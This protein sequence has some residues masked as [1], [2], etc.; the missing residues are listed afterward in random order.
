[1]IPAGN[2]LAFSVASLLLVLL[3][4]PSVLFAIGWALA[5]GRRAAVISVVGNASGMYVQ[6]VAVSLGLGVLLQESIILLTIVKFAGAAFLLYLGIQAIRHRN[7]LVA[8]AAT[9]RRSGVLRTFFE[10]SVVGVTNPKTIV[11]FLAILPQ[12]VDVSGETAVG[13]QMLALG[14]IFVTLGVIFDSLYAILA[15]VARGWLGRSPGRLSGLGVV[16]GV[17]MIGLGVGL[18]VTGT[19]ESA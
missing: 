4:G 6:V 16:G 8:E 9:H 17:A 11:F 15:G 18:A 7:D 12:F 13:V 10:G 14:G 3:P 5:L 2:L 19:A 1:V